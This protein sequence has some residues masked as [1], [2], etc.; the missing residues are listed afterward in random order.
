MNGGV[1]ARPFSVSATGH[2]VWLSQT[3]RCDVRCRLQLWTV[4]VGSKTVYADRTPVEPLPADVGSGCWT[5]GG[6]FVF[7]GPSSADVYRVRPGAATPQPCGGADDD[8][9][10]RGG[11]DD[12]AARRGGADHGAFV[13]HTR[14][15]FAWYAAGR[16]TVSTVRAAALRRAGVRMVVL[17]AET[18]LYPRAVVCEIPKNV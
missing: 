13:C 14:Q 2:D 11:A 5:P 16:L 9:A 17:S 10:G 3:E 6:W 15:G 8:A 18:S 1:F 4:F 12:D 7:C